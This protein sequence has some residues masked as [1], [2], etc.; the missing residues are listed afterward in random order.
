MDPAG[1]GFLV[2][3]AG[4][5]RLLDSNFTNI[6]GAMMGGVFASG[7]AK[8]DITG[9]RFDG[10]TASMAGA[11]LGAGGQVTFNMKDSVLRNIGDLS[12]H[13]A[14]GNFMMIDGPTATISGCT[15]E[16]RNKGL[17]YLAKVSG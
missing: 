15:F 1:G 7:G 6:Q 3:G 16:G 13:F 17:F 9:C 2:E 8:F 4:E 14:W 5:L 12:T 11:F 10:G